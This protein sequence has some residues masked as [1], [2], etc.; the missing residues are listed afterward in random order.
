MTKSTINVAVA[1][2]GDVV[3]PHFGHPDGFVLLTAELETGTIVEEK[4]LTPPPHAPGV[5]PRWLR[6]QDAEAVLAGGMGPRAVDLLSQHG[7][8]AIVGVPPIPYRDAVRAWLSDALVTSG[9]GCDHHEAGDAPRR[10]HGRCG[11]H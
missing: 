9:N 8:R 11:A 2:S 6:E 3:S 1:L 7:I 10:R 5:L 4:R